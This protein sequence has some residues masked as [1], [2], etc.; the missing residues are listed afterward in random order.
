MKIIPQVAL[1]PTWRHHSPPNTATL[2]INCCHLFTSANSPL[3]KT[4]LG[5]IKL[6][7][8]SFAFSQSDRED[9][10]YCQS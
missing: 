2:I 10:G 5:Q 7:G 1:S 3:G 4:H 6:T 9:G 8:G